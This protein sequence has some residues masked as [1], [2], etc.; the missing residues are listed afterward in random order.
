MI[1]LSITTEL[2]KIAIELFQLCLNRR[3]VKKKKSKTSAKA[4]IT[5]SSK[6]KAK[7]DKLYNS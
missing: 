3:K 2:V 4:L 1:M 6:K 7:N 5:H